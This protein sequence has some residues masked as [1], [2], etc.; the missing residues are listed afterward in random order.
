MCTVHFAFAYCKTHWR[1]E[2]FRL[3]PSSCSLALAGSHAQTFHTS[4]PSCEQEGRFVGSMAETS[5][6]PKHARDGP[7]DRKQEQDHPPKKLALDPDPL[8]EEL[9][10][11]KVKE[12]IDGCVDESKKRPKHPH[13]GTSEYSVDESFAD[14]LHAIHQVRIKLLQMANGSDTTT[15]GVL[16]LLPHVIEYSKLQKTLSQFQSKRKPNE[17]QAFQMLNQYEVTKDHYQL[18][19]DKFQPLVLSQFRTDHDLIKK[20]SRFNGYAH[21]I[22]ALQE[23]MGKLGEIRGSGD[24]KAILENMP[25]VERTEVSCTI[26]ILVVESCSLAPKQCV[27]EA[28]Y[29][30]L[31]AKWLCEA[32]KARLS[33]LRAENI[34]D[35]PSIMS[36]ISKST[37]NAKQNMDEYEKRMRKE[38]GNSD[39][40]ECL[41]EKGVSMAEFKVIEAAV[42]DIALDKYK[43]KKL[44]EKKTT[45]EGAIEYN[46]TLMGT[47]KSLKEARGDKKVDA[48]VVLPQIKEELHNLREKYGDD[49]V[50]KPKIAGLEMKVAEMDELLTKLNSE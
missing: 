49:L 46:A 13:I 44:K 40:D 30:K 23:L 27:R 19:K 41:K 20:R 26:L 12:I 35:L 50:M 24:V 4:T 11:A 28:H 10:D 3:I 48:I 33:L 37:A 29:K 15:S 8:V 34:E 39:L 47:L 38:L 14:R 1:V 21:I 43:F 18:L 31:T 6:T 22:E 32:H 17:E 7:S 9:S 42:R 5:S 2:A 36:D 25:K 45:E 16:P